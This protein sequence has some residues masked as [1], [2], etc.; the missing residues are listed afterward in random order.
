[1][2]RPPETAREP[3]RPAPEG[4]E[5]QRHP[6][7]E[8]IAICPRCR[9]AHCASCVSLEF[10]VCLTCLAEA[11]EDVSPPMPFEDR[12]LG[13]A[14]RFLRTIAFAFLPSASA[15]A[16]AMGSTRPALVFAALTFVPLALL[17]G[18][19]PY[20]HRVH[21][22]PTGVV[23]VLP[24][25][26]SGALAV[27]VLTASLLSLAEVSTGILALLFCYVSLARAL[28]AAH[29]GVAAART[30]LY[31]AFLV[32]VAG[33]PTL[34]FVR[35]GLLWSLAEWLGPDAASGY[36]DV[37]FI[38]ACVPLVTFVLGLRKTSRLVLGVDTLPSLAVT[39]VP[40][41]LAVL[42]GDVFHAAIR[43]LHLLPEGMPV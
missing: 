5:C 8:A 24:G 35:Y 31:R 4:L 16:L 6:T 26:T 28:G 18:I 11:P 39:L 37:A 9:K 14:S 13:Y 38:F 36:Y 7:R 30:V 17:R 43:H 41:L 2:S 1:M 42:V 3:L 34:P 12:E 19:I 21:F 25:T 22:G 33:I 32:P 40:V 27:D 23:T 29:V 20:T 10:G 15:P